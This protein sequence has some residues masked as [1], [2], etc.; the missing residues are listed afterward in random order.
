MRWC[1]YLSILAV[2]ACVAAV[3]GCAAQLPALPPAVKPPAAVDD[4]ADYSTSGAPLEKDPPSLE[5]LAA[6]HTF[7]DI[8]KPTVLSCDDWG[9]KLKLAEGA[10]ARALW[11][12][13]CG[14]KDADGKPTGQ[15]RVGSCPECDTLESIRQQAKSAGCGS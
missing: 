4:D 13:D 14:E 11:V 15:Y 10:C 2:V 9:P 12:Q 8:Y 6:G 5:E 7:R 1:R 3:G